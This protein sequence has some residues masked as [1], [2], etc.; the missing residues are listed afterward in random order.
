MIRQDPMGVVAM[1]IINNN[2]IALNLIITKMAIN[3]RAHLCMKSS[4]NNRDLMDFNHSIEHGVIMNIFLAKGHN[5]S[6][7][8][9]E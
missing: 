3:N 8:Q 2:P 6:K 1:I 7:E 4:S 5:M 9:M